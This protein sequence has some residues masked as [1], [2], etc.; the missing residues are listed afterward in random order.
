[1]GDLVLRGS[2]R[3]TSVLRIGSRIEAVLEEVVVLGRTVLGM[4]LIVFQTCDLFFEYK[5]CPYPRI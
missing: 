3:E 4:A 1:M 2:S 5:W